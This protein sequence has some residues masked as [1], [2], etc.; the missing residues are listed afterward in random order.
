MVAAT[1]RR[2]PLPP[3]PRRFPFGEA[4]VESGG[5]SAGHQQKGLVRRSWDNGNILIGLGWFGVVLVTIDRIL[6]YQQRTKIEISADMIQA[7]AEDASRRRTALYEAS[8]DKP[9][10]YRCT[11]V[12]E[13]KSMGGSHGLRDAKVG[14]VVEVLEEN[15]G[16]GNEK[17]YHLC[18]KKE[19][20]SAV[21][22]G[23]E[24]IGWYPIGFM[25]RIKTD[26]TEKRWWL[27]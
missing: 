4:T 12:R 10:L 24:Q 18:R 20:D 23:T 22:G 11:I 1:I 9:A 21:Q 16:I 3:M 15:V 5:A 8:K 14:D 27:F 7:I 2:S 6:Q 25:E 17:N 26:K 13:Y 19:E